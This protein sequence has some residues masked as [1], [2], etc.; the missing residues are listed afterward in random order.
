MNTPG[1]DQINEKITRFNI[2]ATAVM[3]EIGR[4]RRLIFH[5]RVIADDRDKTEWK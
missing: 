4:V 1:R 5:D 2:F 3:R